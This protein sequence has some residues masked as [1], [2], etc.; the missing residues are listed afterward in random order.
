MMVLGYVRA[1]WPPKQQIP[2]DL[3]AYYHTR[4]ELHVEQDCLVRDCQFIPPASLRKRILG[5]AHAGH[6]GVTRMRRK[7]C[8]T[9]WWP[10]LNT[11]V[12]EL[13]GQ[14]VGCQFSGKSTPPT[15]IPKIAIPKPAKTWAKVGLD[16]LGPFVNAPQHQKYIVT[17]ID[18][19]SNFPECLLTTDIC[20]S[21]IAKWLETIFARFG[22]PDELMS[23][24]GPQ[25]VSS[26]FSAFLKCHG[27][28]HTH[29]AVY[30]P[31]ENGLVEVFNRVL[32]F[33]V[34]SFCH[35]GIAWEDWIQE[36]LKAYRATPATPGSRSPAEPFFGRTFRLDFQPALVMRP[37][38]GGHGNKADRL[39]PGQSKDGA[40]STIRANATHLKRGPFILGDLVLTRWPQTLKG[41][42]PFAG[43]FRVMKVL[44][45]YTYPL[46]DGQKW[47]SRLL[48]RFVPPATTWSE[49]L[50]APPPIHE[51]AAGTEERI[52]GPD[53]PDAVQG[54]RRYPERE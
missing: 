9:F 13:V 39:V 26:E 23:D 33:G 32:K 14:C 3:L 1:Q 43:P 18:Y 20:S 44:G 2:A 17:V 31:T 6:P 5:L 50:G 4:N 53:Q 37:F 36:L 52:E 48:K 42:S 16:I 24:N 54:P 35:N 10:G 28:A 45:W 47:N 30:N 19:M 8:E 11:Q 29:A 25:F 22:N 7:L 49:V 51:D 46:S 41:R 38:D 27:I 12:Q 21:C 40:Q 15:D 34:Q